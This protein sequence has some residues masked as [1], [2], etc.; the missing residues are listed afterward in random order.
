M[1]KGNSLSSHVQRFTISALPFRSYYV[2][3]IKFYSH[4]PKLCVISA[5]KLDYQGRTRLGR[6]SHCFCLPYVQI[7]HCSYTYL[8]ICRVKPIKYQASLSS[9]PPT[10]SPLE[11]VVKYYPHCLLQQLFLDANPPP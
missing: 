9:C 3:S 5:I 7:P 8:L 11:R 1:E 4:T 6:H 10:S 2:P